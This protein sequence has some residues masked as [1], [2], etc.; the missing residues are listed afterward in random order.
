MRSISEGL[1][2]GWQGVMPQFVCGA[3][4]RSGETGWLAVR[5]NSMIFFIGSSS[6]FCRVSF[7]PLPI[8]FTSSRNSSIRLLTLASLALTSYQISPR[9]AVKKPDGNHS[10]SPGG[11]DGM[12]S[13]V[14]C[15]VQATSPVMVSGG[16]RLPIGIGGQRSRTFPTVK[17]GIPV[18]QGREDVKNGRLR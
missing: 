5:S 14:R 2:G 1:S 9:K 3:V 4:Q 7:W 17:P 11:M 10:L 8:S 6:T 15:P 12:E 18:L 16:K 13:V